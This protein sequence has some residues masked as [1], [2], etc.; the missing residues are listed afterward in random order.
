MKVALVTGGAVR[1]GRAIVEE[2]A[3]RGWAVA[4]SYHASEA[5]ARELERTLRERGRSAL[6]V[7]V[8]LDDGSQRLS[9]ADEVVARLGGVDALVNNAGVFPRSSLAD[10]APGDLES[11]LR[12]N[13]A[14]PLFLAQA[15]ATHLRARHGSVVNVA[16]IYGLVPLRDHLAYSISKAALL[17]ATRGLAV[18]L[19]PE[20]RVNA[21]APG[22][23]IFPDDYDHATRERLVGRTLLKR[24]GSAAEIASTV[25]FL[26]EDAETMTGQVLV[27]DGGRLVGGPG[28]EA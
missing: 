16:D 15:C 27:V 14:A 2:L 17:A 26:V 12:T 4:F 18:E 20:V 28:P 22:I 7:K 1:I 25:R 23:A 8:D 13:L 9:L 3:G 5:D 11:V 21:I 19:A 10:L 24:A 6:A